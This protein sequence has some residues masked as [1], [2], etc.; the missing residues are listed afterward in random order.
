MAGSVGRANEFLIECGF[1]HV[2]P[3]LETQKANAYICNALFELCKHFEVKLASPPQDIG[4][5][6]VVE[7]AELMDASQDGGESMPQLD[8][9]HSAVQGL[10]SS[11]GM[12]SL[13]MG[14]AAV[15]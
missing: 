15:Y 13:E 14:P 9:F 3:A 4:A 7:H 6:W 1:S 10:M 11:G 5:D 8:S 2:V 12:P